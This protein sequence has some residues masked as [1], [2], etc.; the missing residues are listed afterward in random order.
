MAVL[1]QLLMFLHFFVIFKYFNMCGIPGDRQI[2]NYF[3]FLFGLEY[4]CIY[5][6]SHM[7]LA[8]T[9][10]FSGERGNFSICKMK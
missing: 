9:G 4:V 3:G 10:L 1:I 7:M 6:S 8:T 2:L 5:L